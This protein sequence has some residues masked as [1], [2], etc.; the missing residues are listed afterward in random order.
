MHINSTSKVCSTSFGLNY[1]KKT[2]EILKKS[3]LAAA[4]NYDGTICD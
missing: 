1:G 2:A 3:R 4:K